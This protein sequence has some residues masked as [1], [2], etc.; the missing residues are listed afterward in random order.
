MADELDAVA[1]AREYI[2]SLPT[3]DLNQ[4]ELRKLTHDVEA[5]VKLLKTLYART[6]G[7]AESEGKFERLK[8]LLAGDLKGKKVLI[9]STFKDTARYLHKRLTGDAKFLKVAGN[10]HIRRIDSG[11]HP[12]ERGHIIGQFAP[13]ASGLARRPRRASPSWASRWAEL[14]TPN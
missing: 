8:E 13:V 12:N 4:Y 14:C 5:D 1:E 6:E 2:E 3:V 9:F 10:P 11:N 7:L